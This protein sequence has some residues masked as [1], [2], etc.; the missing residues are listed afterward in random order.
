MKIQ[1]RKYEYEIASLIFFILVIPFLS[2]FP[3][4]ESIYFWFEAESWNRVFNNSWHPPSYL[5][6]LRLFK[7]FTNNAIW[8]GY[9]P[10]LL[11]VLLTGWIIKKIIYENYKNE[12]RNGNLLLILIS[13][14]SLPVII[15]GNFILDIDNTLLTPILLFLTHYGIKWYKNNKKYDF[16]MVGLVLFISLWFKMTTPLLWMS[17]FFVFL[18]V[19]KIIK[20]ITY[21]I[22]PLFIIVLIDFWFSYG[23]LYTKYIL[24]DIGSFQFSGAKALDLIL[25][26]NTFQNS[27]DYLIYS[28]V[29]NTGAIMV[30]SSP[31]LITILVIFYPKYFIKLSDLQIFCVINILF[32]YIVYTFILKLQATAGFPKYHYPMYAFITIIV[33]DYLKNI[34]LIWN[35]Y[36]LTFF[37]FS[38]IACY[39]LVGDVI[40]NYYINGR[41]K[42]YL[43]VLKD[44]AYMIVLSIS[45]ILF[46]KIILLKKNTNNNSLIQAI[47]LTLIILNISGWFSRLNANYSTN[48][49]YGTK[50]IDDTIQFANELPKNK[51]I[52]FPFIGFF[53]EERENLTPYGDIKSDDFT[54]P[55]S[56]YII[57]TSRL[58]DSGNWFF[59]RN[60][61]ENKYLLSRKIFDFEILVKNERKL[62]K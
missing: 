50:G 62:S 46:I 17:S 4:S 7:L 3:V 34:K 8:G 23:Y 45:L 25:G 36:V 5:I 22:V 14:Y 61:L 28:L 38:M 6:I 57:M 44:T 43:N 1:F 18:L 54:K 15:Q 58:I 53:I 60:Y 59:N 9:L 49:W 16:F 37:L 20:I 13:Y 10:G 19:R 48:Y 32:V 55:S 35:F 29:S 12:I 42:N 47:I 39:F 41:E 31:L 27:F 40:I 51:T 2:D 56:D 52:Y 24:S 11:S 30:W 33:F 21:S 26:K